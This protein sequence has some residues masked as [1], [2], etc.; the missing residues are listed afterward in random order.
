LAGVS[1]YIS[2]LEAATALG[3]GRRFQAFLRGG[4]KGVSWGEYVQKR[5]GGVA[6]VVVMAGG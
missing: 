3:I 2:E 4:N 6:K 1:K 5:R